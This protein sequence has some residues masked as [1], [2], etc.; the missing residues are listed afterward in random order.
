MGVTTTRQTTRRF[1]AVTM[2]TGGP[3]TAAGRALAGAAAGRQHPVWCVTFHTGAAVAD[4]R[5]YY[6]KAAAR[7]D[8]RRCGAEVVDV[9]RRREGSG[10]RVVEVLA[11]VKGGM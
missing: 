8:L 1:G 2:T 7:D 5:S 9:E 11:E 4:R 6:T 3:V 10:R